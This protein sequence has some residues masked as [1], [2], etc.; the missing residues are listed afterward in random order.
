MAPRVEAQEAALDQVVARIVEAVRPW[1]IVLFG[2]RAR[3][4]AR[5]ESDYDIYVEVDDTT[6]SPREAH[7][8]IW[9]LVHCSLSIDLKVHARGTIETRRDDPGTIEWD[10]AREGRVL[11]ADPATSSI[12]PS[13]RRGFE[14]P[15]EP[16]KSLDEWI[17]SG[18]RDLRHRQVLMESS[19]DFSPEI[20]WLS[21]QTCE[22]HMK[23][24]L[25]SGW[26]RPDRTHNLAKLLSAL[27]AAGCTLPGLDADCELLSKH[28]ITPCYPA[29]LSLTAENARIASEAADRVLVAVRAELPP[30]VP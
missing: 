29:G 8:R 14:K 24:L 26:V 17:E 25:V 19:E 15:Q 13:P 6:T 20:C 22:K 18:E 11:Y 27:R 1:R 2:S 10:V 30:S 3:G 7:D 4:T 9:S 21:H 28:E 16:P 5:Q 23:A 12:L